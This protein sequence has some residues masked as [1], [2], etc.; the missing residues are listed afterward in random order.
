MSPELSCTTNLQIHIQKETRL[1]IYKQTN[2]PVEVVSGSTSSDMYFH[3]YLTNTYLNLIR[4]DCCSKTIGWCFHFQYS[5][6]QNRH[7]NFILSSNILSRQPL[8]FLI[9]P[10]LAI[11]SYNFQV[12]HLGSVLNGYQSFFPLHCISPMS[13]GREVIIF[14]RQSQRLCS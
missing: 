10:I 3:I 12:I 5:A 13:E 11:I 2:W 1:M 6:T 8:S 9:L 4:P 14:I 7:W